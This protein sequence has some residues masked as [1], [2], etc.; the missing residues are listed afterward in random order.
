MF[1]SSNKTFY[2]N[3]LKNI[4]NDR[5]I[6]GIIGTLII[7]L[8][9]ILGLTIY[10]LVVFKICLRKDKKLSFSLPITLDQIKL[11]F[12]RK[13]TR[14]SSF[15]LEKKEDNVAIDINE[16]YRNS[17]TLR[18]RRPSTPRLLLSKNRVHPSPRTPSPRQSRLI[19]S[20]SHSPTNNQSQT[21]NEIPTRSKRGS[22]VTKKLTNDKIQNDGK[23]LQIYSD[24]LLN[25]INHDSKLQPMENKK[26]PTSKE[27]IDKSNKLLEDIENDLYNL[28]P[29]V[30]RKNK[31]RMRIREIAKK[32]RRNS[33]KK[34][35]LPASKKQNNM[36]IQE[37]NNK[38]KLSP[39]PPP[40]TY[41]VNLE[42]LTT[43]TNN[44]KEKY[45]IHY[46]NKYDYEF[47]IENQNEHIHGNHYL[48]NNGVITE[49]LQFDES[50]PKV[51]PKPK[52]PKRAVPKPPTEPPIYTSEY[53]K[54][55]HKISYQ[56]RGNVLNKIKAIERLK[57]K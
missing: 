21:S 27:L 41:T 20:H 52:R 33:L 6:N 43:N 46:K 13:I 16:R 12:Q 14:N 32:V 42:D 54:E 55:I 22:T 23:Q 50:K 45:S 8:L 53:R 2:N 48:D 35:L 57:K 40:L 1:N 51:P 38:K 29:K 11:S 28:K 30:D 39:R 17:P 9:L 4:K 18:K 34:K 44:L 3:T 56:K 19:K 24:Y 49:T 5:K 36:V 25:E 31:P 47:D 26:S 37:I 15:I 7:L 10:Y